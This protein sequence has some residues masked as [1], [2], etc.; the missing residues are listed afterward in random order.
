MFNLPNILL[1]SINKRIDT[2]NISQEKLCVSCASNF[3]ACSCSGACG[4]YT[5]A[6]GCCS[7]N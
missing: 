7:Y 4:T 1:D 5:P 2:L 6:C 3:S